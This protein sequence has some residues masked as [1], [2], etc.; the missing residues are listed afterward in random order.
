MKCKQPKCG[1]FQ[2]GDIWFE[3]HEGGHVELF[4][5]GKTRVISFDTVFGIEVG[6][7]S[8]FDVD[9]E[10]I[11]VCLKSFKKSEIWRK[12]VSK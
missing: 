2:I 10:N 8:S 5:V 11:D 12:D 6:E 1:D 4:I 7:K 3:R 9:N